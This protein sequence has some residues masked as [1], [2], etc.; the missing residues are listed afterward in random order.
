[1]TTRDRPILFSGPMVRAIL[2]GRKTQ[3][4]RVVN[5]QPPGWL[6]AHLDSGFREV[7]HLHGD[8]FGAMAGRGAVRACR[9][10][11]TV[12]CPYGAPGGRLWV[13]ETWAVLGNDDG[14]P[15]NASRRLCS[16]QQAQRIYRAD[17]SPAPYGLARLPDELG[18]FAGPWRPS[19]HMPRWASRIDLEIVAVRVERVQEI[20]REDVAAEGFTDEFLEWPGSPEQKRARSMLTFERGWDQINGK[21]A[22][23]SANPWVWVL[24]FRRLGS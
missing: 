10:D 21:R 17:T 8:L 23:W 3:T 16:M 22:P 11:A 7:R 14:H 9:S 15:C 1:M 19:I 6:A 4:R 5:P 12:R 20:T 18:D 13:R 2:E 24:T